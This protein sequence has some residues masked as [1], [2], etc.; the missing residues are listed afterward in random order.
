[1]TRVR[2]GAHGGAGR[3]VQVCAPVRPCQPCPAV[4]APACV[5]APRA[6]TRAATERRPP[7]AAAERASGNRD[8]GDSELE[9]RAACGWAAG[10]G[11]GFSP[12]GAEPDAVWREPRSPATHR[13]RDRDGAG[14]RGEEAIRNRPGPIKPGS[15]AMEGLRQSRPSTLSPSHF[16]H[17][18][19]DIATRTITSQ[20]GSPVRVEDRRR[21][22][23]PHESPGPDHRLG[24]KGKARVSLAPE[25]GPT[26]SWNEPAR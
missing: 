7:P 17:E 5:P 11:R 4:A 26:G 22:P 21:S 2:P 15:P 14:G 13:D 10:R 9:G 12:R 23:S 1:V 18:I 3:G 20:P 19:R 25:A 8:P 16:Q 6:G 24:G